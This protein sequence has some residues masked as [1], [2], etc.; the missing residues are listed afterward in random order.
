MSQQAPPQR[1]QGKSFS[2]AS[3]VIFFAVVGVAC[4]ILY[5]YWK[6]ESGTYTD[7]PQDVQITYIPS[8]FK[9]QINEELAVAVLRDPKNNKR[10]FSDLIYTFNLQLLYHVASRMGLDNDKKAM[11]K[12]EYDKHHPYLKQLYYNDFL[13]LKDTTSVT[14][15]SWYGNEAANAVQSLYEVASKYTCFLTNT[16]FLN[17]IKSDAGKMSI[18]GADVATP[19]GVAM[20]EGLAPII[21]KLEERA[22]IED[23]SRK[24]GY[25]QERVEKA[26]AELATMELRDKKGLSKQLSTKVL[27]YNVSTTEVEISAISVVKVGFKLDNYL[28]ISM[29]AKNKRVVVTLPEPVILSHEVYPRVDKLD[30]GW[31]RQINDEDF[32]KNFNILREE[33]RKDA[34]NSD[35]MPKAKKRAN[36]MMDVLL[37]PVVYGLNKNYKL[38]IQYRS[39]GDSD[40]MAPPKD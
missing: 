20:K 2:L 19:C 7:V 6:G 15:Q 27:G 18:K 4:A 12:T 32:N 35:I 29:D 16:I 26:I 8:D 31:I 9:P 39:N 40:S 23:F 28:N 22:A 34:L 36:E 24:K 21:K 14:Y 1:P 37:G 5:K 25:L 10:E 13:A 30:V 11:I 3:T 17:L 38:Q 33:F